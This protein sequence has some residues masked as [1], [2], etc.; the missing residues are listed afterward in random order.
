MAIRKL[1]P[2]TLFTN[3]VIHWMYTIHR[4]AIL[5]QVYRGGVRVRPA[6]RVVEDLRYAIGDDMRPHA[7][8]NS[9][10]YSEWL[11]IEDPEILFDLK[12]ERIRRITVEKNDPMRADSKI[13]L[14][15][16]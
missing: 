7:E 5:Q 16:R 10:E 11:P 13:R 9:N 3:T 15:V 12:V 1:L 4:N 14:G 8:L 6:C 2:N